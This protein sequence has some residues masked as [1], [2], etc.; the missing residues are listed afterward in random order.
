MSAYDN[1][2]GIVRARRAVG[3]SLI[4][5]L[6]TLEGNWSEIELSQAWMLQLRKETTILPFGWYQ[7]PPCGMTVLIGNPSLYD[8]LSYQSLR[9]PENFPSGY[10]FEDESILYA[11]F[12]A[13]DK[14]TLMIGDQVGTFYKGNNNSIK[15][16][17]SEAYST[18][19]RISCLPKHDMLYSDFF[20]LTNEILSNIGAK[21]NTFSISGGLASDVGHSIPFFSEPDRK[22]D[23]SYHSQEEICNIISGGRAFIG[24]KN[25]DRMTSPCAF[26][27]EPQMIV[28]GMP[29]ASFHMII[30]IIDGDVVVIDEFQDIFQYF[31]MD[32]WINIQ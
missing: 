21:N 25:R 2:N 23:W 17:I 6:S 13:V 31:G 18:V 24:P 8:R 19:K 12:S 10:L 7:P 1:L 15:S 16:W 5:A 32:H 4:A 30:S 11:Y 28:D 14:S 20:H 22:L 29:M 27:I 9:H 3:R 26:T